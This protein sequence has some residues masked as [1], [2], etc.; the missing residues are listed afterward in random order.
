MKKVSFWLV[1][2]L[3]A[4]VSIFVPGVVSADDGG[5][6]D[7]SAGAHFSGEAPNDLAGMSMAGVGDVNGDGFGDLLIGAPSNDSGT[8]NDNG[9]AY[10][11]LGG[12]NGWGLSTRLTQ[13]TIIEYFGEGLAGGDN[14]GISVA[15]AGDFNGDGF[16]DLLIGANLNDDGGASAGA[17]YLVLGSA[18]PVGGDLLTIG[19][20]Y[21]GEAAGDQAGVSVAGAGDANGDGFADLLIG[22]PFNG[23]GDNGA[24]Y[25]VLGSSTPPAAGS[26][27]GLATAIKYTGEAA[28]DQA[29]RS[30]AGLGDTNR[31][32]FADMAI[33]APNNADGGAGAGTAYLVPG[34]AAPASV[35]LNIGTPTVV[36]L[37]G[38]VGDGAGQSIAGGGDVNG[39]GFADL[40]VG[41]PL[42]DAAGADAGAAYLVLLRPGLPNNSLVVIGV[43]YTGEAAGEAAGTSVAGAGDTNGDN[44]GDFLVGAPFHSA[45]DNGAG[46]LVLGSAGPTAGSLSTAVR[47][48][49]SL[50]NDKASAVAGAGDVN[51]DGL[52]DFMV[53]ATDNDILFS[54]GGAVYLMFGDSGDSD[55]LAFRQRQNL[56]TVPSTDPQPVTFDQAGVWVNISAG[57]SSA[58]DVNVTRHLFHPCSTNKRLVMPIWTIDSNVMTGAST[59]DLRFKYNEAQLEG[60]VEGTLQLWYRPAGRPCAEWTAVGGTVDT[61]HNFIS[62]SSVIGLGQ[63]TIANAA[64]SPTALNDISFGAHLAQEPAWLVI[65]LAALVLSAGATYWYLRQRGLVVMAE[66]SGADPLMA[67]LKEIKRLLDKA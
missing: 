54:N 59:V 14:A 51:G 41:A 52:A 4:L 61:V 11:V 5:R 21:V 42:N 33:G 65:F 58:G 66:A 53:G 45:V 40:L 17:A 37:T 20:E 15:G 60:M 67:E 50:N 55:S 8:L 30:V 12:L 64:P 46:Y 19:I 28:N 31:D 32:G 2:G 25:L 13:G 27:T 16:N 23:A 56:A 62:V 29:G 48:T 3:V 43:R 49:G 10:L 22:A 44:Y 34:S 63:F 35:G 6:A 9:A 47:Y 57:S 39:D 36:Q 38:G 18:S 24:A 7:G 26:Q 1:L